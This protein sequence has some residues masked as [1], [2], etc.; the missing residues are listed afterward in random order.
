MFLTCVA[1]KT[2]VQVTLKRSLPILLMTSYHN[3]AS[4]LT[5]V[6]GSRVRLCRRDADCSP[7]LTFAPHSSGHPAQ[8]VNANLSSCPFPVSS[9]CHSCGTW[10]RSN[11]NRA[12]S[13][14]CCF[15]TQRLLQRLMSLVGTHPHSW[16]KKGALATLCPLN[17]AAILISCRYTYRRSFCSFCTYFLR[18]RIFCHCLFPRDSMCSR[19]SFRGLFGLPD[20]FSPDRTLQSSE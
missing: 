13:C 20:H 2:S 14:V 18:Q 10:S 12:Q 16:Q 19:R 6:S 17:A 11:H 7:E 15:A 5:D 9:L 4:F 8:A 1:S 3:S